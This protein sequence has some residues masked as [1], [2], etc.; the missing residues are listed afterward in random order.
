MQNYT[1]TGETMGRRWPQVRKFLVF[2]IKLYI[3]AFRDIFLSFLSLGA[4]IIDLI[5][6]NTGAD[7]YFERVLKFGYGTERA[8]NLFNQYGSEEQGSHSVDRVLQEMEDKIR[9]RKK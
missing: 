8:I 2:Q 6:M 4:F 1:A 7:S 9:A 3:D 5:Q